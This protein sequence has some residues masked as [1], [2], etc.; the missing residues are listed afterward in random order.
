VI[1]TVQRR[2]VEVRADGVLLRGDL[3]IP[4]EPCGIILFAHGSG[5]GRLSPRN[6]F[7]AERLNEHHLATLLLD[8]LTED[9]EQV[10]MR[11]GRLRFDIGLLTDRLSGATDW[12][13]LDAELRGYPVGYFGA[14]TGAAAALAASVRHPSE[15]QAVVSRGGR[16]D[17]A[18][19]TLERV[20]APTLLIVGGE[21][22]V[23]LQLNQQ[24][25]ERIHAE[26]HLEVVPGASHLFEEPG[27]LQEVSRLAAD[28]FTKHLCKGLA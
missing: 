8:L 20:T 26:V 21:D 17:M 18:G 4:V 28:W 25:M 12:L 6:Q 9:E 2:N 5:S 19:D 24:A 1:E 27:K 23:V 11:T 22:D 3:R 16:P 15:V 13:K 7:V 14:S 10:D